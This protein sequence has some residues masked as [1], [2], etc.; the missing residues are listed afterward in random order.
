MGVLEQKEIIKSEW[1]NE[2]VKRLRVEKVCLNMLKANDEI[3]KGVWK[4]MERKKKL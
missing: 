3:S 2:E 1:W 4:Y